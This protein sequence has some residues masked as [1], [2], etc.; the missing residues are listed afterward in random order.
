MKQY[1]SRLKFKKN[2]K[3]N[4]KFFKMEE[5]KTFYPKKGSFSLI[6]KASSQATFNQ[7]EAARKSIRRNVKKQGNVLIRTFTH[8]SVTKKPLASRMGKGKGSHHTWVCPVKTGQTIAELSDL[9]KWWYLKAFR[10]ASFRLPMIVE[11]K[12]LK[13]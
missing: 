8:F 3:I 2:H 13:Y 7:I 4:K 12:K 1:P 11:A 10:S 6:A 9:N 5:Q